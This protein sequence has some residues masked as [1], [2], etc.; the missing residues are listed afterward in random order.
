M[1]VE[2][3]VFKRDIALGAFGLHSHVALIASI[4]GIHTDNVSD[5]ESHPESILRLC[6]EERGQC[7]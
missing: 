2:V 7:E 1:E 4:S 6:S 3:S 5:S